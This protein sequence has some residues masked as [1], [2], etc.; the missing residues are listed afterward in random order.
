MQKLKKAILPLSL[1]L[2]TLVGAS[3]CFFVE[4]KVSAN[5]LSKPYTRTAVEGVSVTDEFKNGFMDFSLTLFRNTMT[6]DENNDLL[7][8]LSAAL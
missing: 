7:S 3:G 5:E 4:K 8:P 2:T 1:C 6:K